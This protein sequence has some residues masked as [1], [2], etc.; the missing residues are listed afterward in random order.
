MK[1][2]LAIMVIGMNLARAAIAQGVPDPNQPQAPTSDAASRKAQAEAETAAYNAAAAA[3]NA[4][5]AAIEAQA[6]ADKAKFGGVTG[7]STL[8]GTVTL[9]ADSAKAEAMLLVTRSTIQAAGKIADDLVELVESQKIDCPDGDKNNGNWMDA[10]K[11]KCYRMSATRKDVLI[12]NS[13]SELS[14][15]DLLLYELQNS[16]VNKSLSSANESYQKLN[17]GDT[18]APSTSDSN[19][20]QDRSFFPAVGAVL[21]SVTKLG[22]YFQANYGFG[23]VTPD[24]PANLV[25]TAV[26]AKMKQK[27]EAK[28]LILPSN[29][30]AVDLNAFSADLA[31]LQ[32]AYVTA[33]S[34]LAAAKTRSAQLKESKNNEDKRLAAKYDGADAALSKAIAA[35]DAFTTALVATQTGQTEPTI[36]KIVKQKKIRTALN[37]NP[38][39]LMISSKNAAAYY[40]KK[41]LWTFLGGAPLYTMGGVAISYSIFDPESGAI[42]KAGVVAEHGGYRSVKNVE[43][44]FK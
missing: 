7:Q 9:G 32:S 10:E 34:N 8:D 5:K 20:G 1:K 40:T 24:V 44:L 14:L 30:M 35:F 33:V 6:A 15:S 12:L 22:S 39:I 3:A 17:D 31:D 4:Q 23:G 29:F 43:K 13:V 19:G 27:G 25:A 18:A 2:Q 11:S 16:F 28:G 42:L 37:G 36:S 38:L 41:S 21:D 26:I